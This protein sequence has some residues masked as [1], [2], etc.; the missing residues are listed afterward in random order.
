MTRKIFL[1]RSWPPGNKKESCHFARGS[2]QNK[3]KSPASAISRGN[4]LQFD[5]NLVGNETVLIVE[6]DA[7]VLKLAKT[8]LEKF[9]YTVLTTNTPAEAIRLAEA[10]ASTI[11]LVLTDIIMPEMNGRELANQLRILNPN[12][13][14]L[15]MSGY[16][17]DVIAHRGMLDKGECFIHKP[18]SINDLAVKMREALEQEQAH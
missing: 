13:N 6:D 3:K 7:S 4:L 15:F 18:F 5:I 10:N 16:T 11:H 17:A 8:M 14:I 2:H 9:G 12:F 1:F